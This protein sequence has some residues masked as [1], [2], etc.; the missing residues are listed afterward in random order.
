[1]EQRSVEFDAAEL[2]RAIGA[3]PRV[4]E[5]LGLRAGQVDDVQFLPE[6]RLVAFIVPGDSR[7]TTTVAAEGL[8]AL[9]VAYC[10]RIGVPL[11]RQAKKTIDVAANRVTLR[12]T[13]E[14]TQGNSPATLQHDYPGAMIWPRRNL[15]AR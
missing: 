2:L 3:A 10:S 15:G 6:Q 11:P 8:V 5:A 13:V 7:R 4:A 1:M 12:I 14:N 9:L